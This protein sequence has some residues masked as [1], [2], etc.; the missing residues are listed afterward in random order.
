MHVIILSAGKGTRLRPLTKSKPK[1]LIEF[2]DGETILDKQLK[3][4]T[5]N[6]KV[7]SISIVVGYLSEMIESKVEEDWSEYPINTRYNPFV[8]HS[9]NLVS[10]WLATLSV[11]EDFIITNGDNLFEPKVIKTLL[12]PEEPGA[13]LTIDYKQ[14]Y[15]SDDMRVHFD[16]DGYVKQVSKEIPDEHTDAES[17]GI[18]RFSGPKFVSRGKKTLHKL[19]RSDAEMDN[20]WL[21]LFTELHE[22][23]IQIQP[24]EVPVDSWYEFDIH[25]DKSLFENIMENNRTNL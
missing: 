1:C 8:E 22:E 15:E 25:S 9:D 17:I 23:G 4:L 3:V 13:Y 16:P 11:D 10:L 19:V 18:A 24:V 2:D 7:D 14:S 6:E 21:R 5:E 20:Y 12:E